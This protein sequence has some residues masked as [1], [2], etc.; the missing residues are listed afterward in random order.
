VLLR[1]RNARR[2][3]VVDHP[4]QRLLR[5]GDRIEAG[6]FRHLAARVNR[7]DRS[8][9]ARGPAAAACFPPAAPMVRTV[10]DVIV[11]VGQAIGHQR[12]H[13]RS[14]QRVRSGPIIAVKHSIEAQQLRIPGNRYVDHARALATAEKRTVRSRSTIT[15]AW[16]LPAAMP[17]S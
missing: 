3:P 10:G 5:V 13:D 12:H 4:L 11:R 17:S 2:D 7:S 16:S 8:S 14:L 6:L 9:A 1:V 15:G